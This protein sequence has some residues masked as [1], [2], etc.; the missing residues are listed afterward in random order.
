MQNQPAQ[1]DFVS[2]SCRT[3]SGQLAEWGIE[4]SQDRVAQLTTEQRSE[5]QT[6]INAGVDADEAYQ[7]EFA[8]LPEF[9]ENELLE[10]SGHLSA[11]PQKTIIEQAINAYEAETPLTGNPYLFDTSAWHLWRKAYCRWHR[12]ETLDFS[13]ETAASPFESDDQHTLSEITQQL[14]Q[15]TPQLHQAEQSLKQLRR[16]WKQTKRQR[17]VFRKQ[18]SRLLLQLCESSGAIKKANSVSLKATETQPVTEVKPESTEEAALDHERV[19]PKASSQPISTTGL[20]NIVRIPVTGPETNRIEVFLQQDSEGQWRAGHLWSVEA[21]GI[22]GPLSR[23]SRQPNQ[24]QTA[25]ATETDALLKEVLYLSQGIIGVP[26]IESQIVD[27]LNLLEEYPGQIAVCGNCHRHYINGGID[28]QDVCP[29]C[30][31]ELD[32]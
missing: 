18:Q 12:G 6:W 7:E 23:G 24:Q 26:E 32:L 13:E 27:Y 17:N 14:I 21:D 2:N 15:L 31:R 1:P 19:E 20:S 3:I 28:D 9:M 30:A 16:Q 4:F 29:E 10:I 8:S 22:T 25:Y 5:L 11:E